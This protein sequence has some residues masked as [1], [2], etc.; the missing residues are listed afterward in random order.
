MGLPAFNAISAVDSNVC[1]VAGEHRL[2]VRT[3]DGGENWYWSDNGLD[4]DGYGAV[5]AKSASVAWTASYTGKIYQTIDSGKTWALQYS[6]PG[7]GATFFDAIYFWDDQNGIAL[8]DPPLYPA[9]CRFLILRTT[10]GGA[11]WTPDTSGVPIV[12]N[13]YGFTMDFDVT[14]DHFWFGSS[15]SPISPGDTTIQTIIGHS[16]DRG[17]TWETLYAPPSFGNVEVAF[18][19]SLNGLITGG[20]R[21]IARTTDGG[22]SWQMRYTGVGF[23]SEF[24]KGSGTVWSSG[25]HLFRSDDYGTS[26][27][28]LGQIANPQV[29]GF[30]VVDANNVWACGF[31]YLIL[32]TGVGGGTSGVENAGNTP[33]LPSTFSVEQ[34]YPNPFNPATTIKYRLETSQS[35]RLVIYD[36]LGREIRT[37]LNETQRAGWHLV[38]WDGRDWSGSV[39][40]TGVYVYRL[41]GS[42]EMQSRKM[43]LVK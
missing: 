43:L 16:S 40:A 41:E 35:V 12:T 6:Y 2:L 13:Q 24:L 36:A 3:T 14:G 21:H 5:F 25:D 7:P 27:N 32:R 11:V 22:K 8:G 38:T 15:T 19:D 23:Q 20:A 17:A 1:W 29:T 9:A 42:N 30:S 39:V 4:P 37:L 34:N 33:P 18:S 28:D 31:D 10:N 26:W